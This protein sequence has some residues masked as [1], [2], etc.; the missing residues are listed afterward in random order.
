MELPS[1]KFRYDRSGE[2]LLP[3][4]PPFLFV[5]RLIAGD[6]TGAVGEYTFTLEK[7]DFFRGHFPGRPVV[8]GVVLV[9]AMAQVAGAWV[10][11]RGVIAG[12]ASFAIAAIDDVRFRQPFHPGDKLVTVTE[13]VRERVPLGVYRFKG[14]LN[15]EPN[16]RGEPAAE[17][18]VKCMMSGDAGGGGR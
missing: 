5:D 7:N 16:A 3:H 18:T 17:C 13:S 6:E 1:F 12:Q 14:Y 10:V 11:E 2:E 8:P 4:R 15:G 9:E